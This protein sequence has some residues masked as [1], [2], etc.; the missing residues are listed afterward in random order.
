VSV[1]RDEHELILYH[2]G[3]SDDPAATAAHL[4]DC[5]ACRATADELALVLEAVDADGVPARGG[6]Y[7]RKVWERLEP[8][9]SRSRAARGLFRR[10]AG[11]GA[12]AA[13]LLVAFLVGRASHERER[14]LAPP[15]AP[16]VRE[17]IL[18]VAV[19]EHL[20]RSQM[21]LIELQ[22][23]EP[24]DEGTV[25]IAAERRRAHD[26]VPANRLFRRAAVSAGEAGVASVL[27]ELERVLVEVAMSPDAVPARELE[28]I[29]ER[30]ESQ[31]IVFKVRV[32]GSRVRGR[33]QGSPRGTGSPS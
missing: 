16:P 22:N 14:T 23:A 6:D 31:G 25:D 21:L 18:L 13:S 26:L 3:E 10:L 15:A 9:L 11:V 28:R 19:G 29:R 32:L 24:L 33:G 5:V 8:R 20:E 27:E 12:V 7:G 30:M 2:Y 4:R 17:R 1:H